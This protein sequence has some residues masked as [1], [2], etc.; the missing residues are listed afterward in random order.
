[1]ELDA[2]EM[3]MERSPWGLLTIILIVPA[4]VIFIP[5]PKVRSWPSL[6]QVLVAALCAQLFVYLLF[7]C[8][9]YPA[10]DSVRQAHRGPLLLDYHMLDSWV[11][12]A[13]WAVSLIVSFF[14]A[15]IRFAFLTDKRPNSPAI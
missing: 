15:F 4:L 7:Y 8:L 13:F 3:L 9:I 5:L 6:L 2:F 10:A 11:P 14:Y 1:M 12:H